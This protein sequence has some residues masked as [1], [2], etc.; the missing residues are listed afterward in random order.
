MQSKKMERRDKQSIITKERKK[1]LQ[2]TEKKLLTREKQNET[3]KEGIKVQKWEV[4]KNEKERK[5]L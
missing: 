2:W 1:Y 4:K 5:K 3:A